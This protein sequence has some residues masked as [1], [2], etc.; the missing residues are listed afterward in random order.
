MPARELN[1]AFAAA[2]ECDLLFT[3]GTSGLVQP[4]AQIP[5]MAK[6]AGASVVEVNP[7]SIGN[8]RECTWCLRG[9]AGEIMPLLVEMAFEPV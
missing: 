3:I 4:A 1:M 7:I 6:Q 9:A 8:D 2:K 5:S